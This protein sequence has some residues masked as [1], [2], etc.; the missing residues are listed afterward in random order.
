MIISFIGSIFFC[1]KKKKKTK[2]ENIN[3]LDNNTEG[4]VL[5]IKPN[6]EIYKI[7]KE[8]IDLYNEIKKKE[9]NY[10]NLKK[11]YK[12][13][14][15]EKQ[16]EAHDLKIKYFF[17]KNYCKVGL[18][19]L[20]NTCYINSVI[21]ILKNIP[22][23]TYNFYEMND[24]SDS[25]LLCFKQLLLNLCYYYNSAFLPID[26]K[27]KLGLEDKKFLGNKQYDSTIFYISLI[28]I[29]NKKLNKA[30]KE[31]Y[32]KFDKTKYE[33]IN[34]EEKFLKWK[35]C[36]LS[37]NQSFIID[38][39]YIYFANQ[40]KCTSCQN[41]I[42]TFQSTNF[43][44]FPIIS[45]ESKCLKNLEDCFEN[46]QKINDVSGDENFICSKCGECTLN[47]QFILIELPPILII[48]L[49][50]VGEKNVYY[51]DIDIPFH[52]NMS[53]IIKNKCNNSI[54]ELKGF[55]KHNGTEKGGH[56]YAF[57]KNMYDDEWYEYNDSFCRA[58]ESNPDLDK[59]F[60]LCYI[61]IG[62]EIEDVYNLKQITDSF[63]SYNILIN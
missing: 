7:E 57:C 24:D 58:I 38:L 16:K 56:N 39:F 23:F 6:D 2:N 60:L 9:L 32:K 17:E 46:F 55:I 41:E 13:I 11:N 4:K 18:N 30:K 37:K 50:R 59:I 45:S 40:I 5:I 51:N 62:N 19:N 52:L 10:L 43:L 47:L 48:N 21:Q 33:N 22:K 54:Y 44:D 27:E 26:F 61:K 34:F 29:L 31:N 14:L 25:F 15:L 20:G 42:H 35:E 12:N 53:K 49:K 3:N 1:F 28:N 8:M 36:F 63:D